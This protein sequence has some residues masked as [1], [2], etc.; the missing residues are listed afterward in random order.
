MIAVLQR[1][2]RAKVSAKNETIG[3]IRNGLLIL[4]GVSK[5]D[6]ESD[7]IFLADKIAGF[8]IFQDRNEN[9]NLSIADV[10]GSILVVSQFTLCAD[11]RKGRRPSFTKAAHPDDGNRLYKY[12][13]EQLS[14]KGFHVE[15]GSFGAMMDVELVNQGP[16][17]FVLDS[18]E[19]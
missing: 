3:E 7:A 10:N 17:T 15:T 11:W 8:R 13:I 16:V 4:L 5:E 19:K 6:S 1:V 9:M 2:S 12:F 18:R 14:S